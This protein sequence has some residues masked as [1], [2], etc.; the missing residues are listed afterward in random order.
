MLFNTGGLVKV[1][2]STQPRLRRGHTLL[3]YLDDE[4]VQDLTG[5]QRA[6]DLTEVPRGEHRLYAE[7]RDDGGSVV[8]KSEAVLFTVKQ[9]SIQNPN[10]PNVP[11]PTPRPRI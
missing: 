5:N 2:V 4:V 10:N 9:T 6:M 1:S 11:T 3:I 7:V 8:E